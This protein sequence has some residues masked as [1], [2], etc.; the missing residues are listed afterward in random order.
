MKKILHCK[1]Y[2]AEF[3]TTA[4]TELQND[5][6]T[7]SR[8]AAERGRSHSYKPGASIGSEQ[9]SAIYGNLPRRCCEKLRSSHTDCKFCM[10]HWINSGT[11]SYG[12][13]DLNAFNKLSFRAPSLHKPI[14]QSLSTATL[15]F[16]PPS[17][18]LVCH[19]NRQRLNRVS[20]PGRCTTNPLNSTRTSTLQIVQTMRKQTILSSRTR[21]WQS[22]IRSWLHCLARRI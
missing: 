16:L 6:A 7:S 10:I 1:P 3:A 14:Y 21:N 22:A 17:N 13:R 20:R 9:I 19:T 8:S 18:L 5:A 11:Y 2:P 12:S 15:P 4:A